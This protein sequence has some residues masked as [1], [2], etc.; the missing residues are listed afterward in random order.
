M[1]TINTK[2]YTEQRTLPDTVVY[3]GPNH[4]LSIKDLLELKRVNPKPSKNSPGV[5]RPN[6]TIRWSYVDANTGETK[7][8]NIAII[9]SLPVGVDL[10]VVSTKLTDLTTFATSADGLALFQKLDIKA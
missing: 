8:A 9:G 2:S 4:T 6:A 10:S 7:E 5:A 1:P 3:S